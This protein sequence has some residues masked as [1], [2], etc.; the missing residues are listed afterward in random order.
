MK[1]WPQHP[2][3]NCRA[4]CWQSLTF[5]RNPYCTI[6]EVLQAERLGHEHAPSQQEKGDGG[7]MAHC[8]SF[9]DSGRISVWHF[10]V[11]GPAVRGLLCW[12]WEP[13]L[14]VAEHQTRDAW[15]CMEFGSQSC[16]DRQSLADWEVLLQRFELDLYHPI[17]QL[18]ADAS[19]LFLW[20]RRRV[21]GL[22]YAGWRSCQANYQKQTYQTYLIYQTYQT[23]TWI[24]QLRNCPKLGLVRHVLHICVLTPELPSGLITRQLEDVRR[25][26]FRG[27][28]P[29]G[30]FSIVHWCP[31]MS[32]GSR[33]ILCQFIFPV[34]LWIIH[35]FVSLSLACFFCGIRHVKRGT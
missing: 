1:M 8:T 14:A 12:R 21:Q 7:L 20:S 25:G 17:G 33:E 11:A 13:D 19:G 28:W 5:C 24:W 30:S 2:S 23:V 16:G 18:A 32:T 29:S 26:P 10:S 34:G 4:W 22:P 15:R 31:L 27:N 9:I 6:C 35:L 3:D